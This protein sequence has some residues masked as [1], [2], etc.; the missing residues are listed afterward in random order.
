[1][2]RLFN[3]FLD[4][5]VVVE[6]FQLTGELKEMEDEPIVEEVMALMDQ[7]DFTIVTEAI[8]HNFLSTGKLTTGERKQ[9]L[10]V[11]RLFYSKHVFEE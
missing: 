6:Q 4:I 2:E 5:D 7:A 9:L 3:D 11:Y 1:M 8:L 10:G